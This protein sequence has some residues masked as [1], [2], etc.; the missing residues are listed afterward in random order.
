MPAIHRLLPRSS[1][2]DEKVAVNSAITEILL[3][4]LFLFLVSIILTFTLLHIRQKKR[5]EESTT[6]ALAKCPNGSSPWLPNHKRLT[7]TA[8][9]VWTADSV[10]SR[11]E[12]QGLLPPLPAT[13]DSPVPE[14]RI[15][16]PEE[17]D[18]S[19]KRQ[20]G[21]VVVVR[22]GDSGVALE[23]VPENLPPYP[24]HESDQ[25]DSLDLE[26]IGGLKEK[27]YLN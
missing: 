14:I 11:Q 6:G 26:R 24:G 22:L 10:C 25:F 9:P 3:A 18:A 27:E 8:R 23:P 15:T 13:P 21:R 20:S 1:P 7:I 2:E 17:F 5:L 19:G 4:F 12:K 16:F